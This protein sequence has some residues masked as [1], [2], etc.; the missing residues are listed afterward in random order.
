MA[1]VIIALFNRV[2]FI[3]APSRTCLSHRVE[4]NCRG[5]GACVQLIKEYKLSL[6]I[7]TRAPD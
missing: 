7:Q 2:L 4:C 5:R 3:G 6:I 1:N